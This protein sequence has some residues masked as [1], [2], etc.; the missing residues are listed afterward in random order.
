MR[1]RFG[2]LLG[3]FLGVAVV[4]LARPAESTTINFASLESLGTPGTGCCSVGDLRSQGSTVTVDGFTF[5]SSNVQQLFG[6]SVWAS[7]NANHPQGGSPATSLFEYAAADTTTMTKQGGG[8]FTLT[9]IDFAEYNANMAGG[10]G[11]FDVTLIG[12]KGDSSIVSQTVQVQRN[13]GSPQ[14][15]SFNLAGF[16]NVIKVT[17]TQGAYTNNAFQFNNLIVTSVPDGGSTLSL[18]TLAGT[19]LV[20]LKRRQRA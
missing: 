8:M 18:L 16:T 10:P 4:A 5:T 1:V 2:G 13:A 9:G 17:M 14:L 7:Y 6:L 19:C 3:V 11:T 12:T 20:A 15:Q